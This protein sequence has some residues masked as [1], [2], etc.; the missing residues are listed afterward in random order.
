MTQGDSMF[1]EQWPTFVVA[2]TVQNIGDVTGNTRVSFPLIW[3]GVAG[4][5]L[6]LALKKFVSPGVDLW[7]R[8]ETDNAGSPSGTLMDANATATVLTSGLTTSL[9]DTTVTL[10]WSVTPTLWTKYH[11]VAYAGTYGSETV[12]GTNYFGIGYSTNNT[13]TRGLKLWNATR[14]S[15]VPAKRCY[16]SSTLAT[17]KLLSKTDADFTYKLPDIP[18]LATANYAIWELVKYDFAGISKLLSGLTVDS[19]YYISN[20]P[21]A[22]S[23]SAGTNPYIIWESIYDNNL[24]IITNKTS[25]YFTKNLADSSVLQTIAHTLWRIPNKITFHYTADATSSAASSL[26][27]SIYNWVSTINLW[28]SSWT[29]PVSGLITTSAISIFTSTWTSNIAICTFDKN[30]IYLNWTKTSTPTWSRIIM[31]EVE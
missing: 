20:T 12:N 14:W 30:N 24:K 22:L 9:V 29:P 15:S 16:L 28:L 10:A 23:T 7:I 4:N 6:K 5:T 27:Y 13:T 26:Y 17:D 3:S 31:R 21:G 25:W 1:V 18:R 2:T 19:V 8:I 11:V